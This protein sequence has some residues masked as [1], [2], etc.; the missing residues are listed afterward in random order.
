M[1]TGTNRGSL[2]YCM[3]DWLSD[4]DLILSWLCARD[5]FSVMLKHLVQH[6]MAH[7]LARSVCPAAVVLLAGLTWQAQP[8]R[9]GCGDYV[10]IGNR[11]Q[12]QPAAEHHFS[13]TKSPSQPLSPCAQGRCERQPHRPLPAAPVPIP[14][15]ETQYLAELPGVLT[16]SDHHSTADANRDVPSLPAGVPPR[17]DRPPQI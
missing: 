1:A 3:I 6:R 14:G 12:Q 2:P 13:D 11:P 17:I 7:S 8:V 15:G 16:P 5:L 10:L 9:A 4:A